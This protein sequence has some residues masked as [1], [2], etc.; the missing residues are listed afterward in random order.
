MIL[1]LAVVA[2]LVAGVARAR[3]R[4]RPYWAIDLKWGGLVVLA[5]IPQLLAFHILSTAAYIP[6]N[7]ASVILVT[8]QLALVAFVL[9]NRDK[10]GFWLLGIGLGLNLAVILCN[11]GWMPISP[12]TVERLISTSAAPVGSIGERFWHEQGHRVAQ[13]RDAPLVALR[14][15]DLPGWIPLARG[16]QRRGCCSCQWCF[17]ATVDTRGKTF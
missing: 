9:A 12:E 3:A 2:G 11:G 5:V 7:S 8:S 14:P 6:D 10:P 16:F 17:L 13:G 1:L 4:R 15:P